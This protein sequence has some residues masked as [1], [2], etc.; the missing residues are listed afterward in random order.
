MKKDETRE[1]IQQLSEQNELLKSQLM[2]TSLIHELTKVLHSC[3]DF[4]GII[5]TVLLAIQE[6]LEFDRS[7]FLRSTKTNSAFNQAIRW[8]SMKRK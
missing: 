3:T 5:K 8:E 7:S 1:L 6:I 2:N 4:E